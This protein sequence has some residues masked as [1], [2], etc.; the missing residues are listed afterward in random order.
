MTL[1][2]GLIAKDGWVL[3]DDRRRVD[4]GV[5]VRSE[6]KKIAVDQS[7]GLSYSF[8]GDDCAI[9]AGDQLA[10]NATTMKTLEDERE[11]RFWLRSLGNKTWEQV[12]ESLAVDEKLPSSH[13]Y[14]GL[15]VFLAS[16]LHHFWFLQIGQQT[17]VTEI[18]DRVVVGDGGNGS[19]LFI[20]HHYS[21]EMTIRELTFLAAHTITVGSMLNP[22]GVGG[23]MD[24]V[25]CERD[26]SE[27]GTI[28]SLSE[29][30]TKDL[31]SRSRELDDK[32]A[33]YFRKV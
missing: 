9:I 25:V 21:P 14:R 11:L 24:I 8:Y 33:H 6:I 23:G 31:E 4:S 30:E 5:R 29:D 15:L 32:I 17:L 18:M 16:S 27:L 19:R 7:L 2:I 26:G 3:A 28:R 22:A 10:A 13:L 20:D 1:Q 12:N